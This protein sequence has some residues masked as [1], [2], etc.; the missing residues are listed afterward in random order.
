VISAIGQI[1][2]VSGDITRSVGFYRDKL[3]IRLLF[4]APP[5]MAFFDCG[6]VRLMLGPQENVK[7]AVSSI[8]YFKVDDIQ[9]AAATLKSRGIE[10]E[11]DPHLVAK[12]PD[13]DLWLAFF[14]DPDRNALALMCEIKRKP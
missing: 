12:M 7:D 10:F 2:L 4:E 8:V 3:G 6:G 5:G 9:A 1:G 14:R 11:R 13:H